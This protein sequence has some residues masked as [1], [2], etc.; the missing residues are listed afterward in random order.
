MHA[1]SPKIRTFITCHDLMAVLDSQIAQRVFHLY[2]YRCLEDG[3]SLQAGFEDFMQVSRPGHKLRK[4]CNP[5]YEV[6]V[7]L[8]NKR[9]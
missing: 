8:G 7:S 6:V 5:N 4:V 1:S 3:A 9:A 2:L